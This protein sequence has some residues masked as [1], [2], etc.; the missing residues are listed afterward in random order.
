MTALIMHPNDEI[1]FTDFQKEITASLYEKGR[2]IYS[3]SPL[4]IELG[5]FNLKD[6]SQI[7]QVLVGQLCLSDN[8]VY[9]PV[10]IKCA[11]RKISSKLTLVCLHKG[12]S[13]TEAELAP[14]K[15]KPE[16]QIKVFRLGVEKELSSISKCITESKWIKVR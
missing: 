1:F 3:Q 5:D 6:K 12:K 15:E 13:F 11:D 8:S 4:W 9:C 10:E 14:L 7:K 2:I 16:R